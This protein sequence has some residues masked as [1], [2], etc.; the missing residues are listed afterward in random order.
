M[1]NSL[2][3]MPELPT[4]L[5][6]V[7]PLT[8]SAA[9]S[10]FEGWWAQTRRRSNGARVE[11][12]AVAKGYLVLDAASWA[13]CGPGPCAPY[14]RVRGRLRPRGRR[15]WPVE[16]ELVPWSAE[17]SELGLRFVGRSGPVHLGRYHR[18]A[19]T[20]IDVVG[21]A[22]LAAAPAPVPEDVR[23]RRPDAA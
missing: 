1:N 16:L 23:T 5:S 9:P 4:Y 13:R 15:G 10:V 3:P 20:V 7:L 17:R 21:S 11:S 2:E 8:A 18:M 12:L 6:K 14:R 19:A 22:I